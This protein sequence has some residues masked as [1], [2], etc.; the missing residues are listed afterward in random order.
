MTIKKFCQIIDKAK[1]AWENSGGDHRS[2]L[3]YY[4]IKCNARADLIEAY[5]EVTLIDDFWTWLSG[6]NPSLWTQA[7]TA[8]IDQLQKGIPCMDCSAIIQY[9]ARRCD[10]CAK[11]YKT[12]LAERRAVA[13]I[14]N[15]KKRRKKK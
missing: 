12:L 10:D 13:N 7:L 11:K 1:D 14:L 9:P 3:E 15:K 6:Y 2:W 5:P 4:D 8:R